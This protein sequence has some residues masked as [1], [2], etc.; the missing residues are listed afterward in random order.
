MT[1]RDNPYGREFPERSTPDPGQAGSMGGPGYSP[2][3][4][5][6]SLP[7]RMPDGGEQM[8]QKAGQLTEQAKEQTR[9]FFD[10]QRE[11]LAE[12]L[13][14]VATALRQTGH[15]LSDQDRGA[16]AQYADRAADTMQRASSY[17]RDTSAEEMLGSV[18]RYARREPALFLGGALALGFL[19]ARFLKSSRR[20]EN[21]QP[22]RFPTA[23][24]RGGPQGPGYTGGPSW[25]GEAS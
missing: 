21:M 17:L 5:Q 16:V 24:F 8:K 15:Q 12:G 7:A 6:S 1:T 13:G 23:S 9:S 18:E 10:G 11:R 4:S 25:P 2:P 19:G 20:R 3:Y 14:G 22:G